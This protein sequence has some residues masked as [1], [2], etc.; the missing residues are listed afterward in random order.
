MKCRASASAPKGGRFSVD[1]TETARERLV[2]WPIVK[3][4]RTSLCGI[5]Q[6]GPLKTLL[7]S[8]R[9]ESSEEPQTERHSEIITHKE[10]C[11]RMTQA[12][13]S[14]FSEIGG[15]TSLLL[16]P[17]GTERRLPAPPN[18]LRAHQQCRLRFNNPKIVIAKGRHLRAPFGSF[19]LSPPPSL[20]E[21]RRKDWFK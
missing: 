17:E 6:A 14:V 18:P 1:H 20:P 9:P 3:I 21:G 15:V 16:I 10:L 13:L 7:N 5:S 12:Q 4:R 19:F 8:S 2:E 11:F